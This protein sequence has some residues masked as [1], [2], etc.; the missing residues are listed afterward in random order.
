MNTNN[1]VTNNTSNRASWRDYYDLTKPRVVLLLMVTA[2]GGMFLAT[3]P[4]GM[5]PLETLLIGSFGL[6]LAM[7]AS[8]VINQIADQRIDKV[9]ARTKNR[10]LIQ[11]NISSK[12]AMTFAFIMA[13]LSM[14]ILTIWINPLTALLTLSGIIGY[15]FIYT[16]YLKRATPQNIVVGGLAGAIPPLLGWTAVTNTLDPHALLLVLIIF[17]WTPPHFWAL[18]IAKVEE[19]RKAEIPMLPVTHGVEFTKT[20]TLLYSIL[21]LI[22]STLPFF[23]GMSGII[24][25]GSALILGLIFCYYCWEL[26]QTKQAEAEYKIGMKTFGWSIIY[27]ALLFAVLLIDHYFYFSLS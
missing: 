12:Q 13:S 16:A 22:V 20:S 9:M 24:Y 23:T 26:K 18:A 17:I 10:P 11:G 2:V 25:L 27:L 3:N 14:V 21:L 19:Y 4:A 6:W 5:V 15:A 7:S 8:A 1:S